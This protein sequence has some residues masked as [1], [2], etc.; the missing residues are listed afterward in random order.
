[1]KHV[2]YILDP[3]SK[4]KAFCKCKKLCQQR[5]VENAFS[6]VLLVVLS[7]GKVTVEID[8]TKPDFNT[9]DYVPDDQLIKV[10]FI[11]VTVEIDTTKPDF[12]T[13]DFVPNDQLIKVAAIKVTVEIDT[14]KPDF[15]TADYVPDD[16]LIKVLGSCYQSYSGD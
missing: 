5:A 3:A 13:A 16:Q 4:I 15:I 9:A 8:T 12:I 10:G 6:K 14:T 11:K 2:I 1:M 7:N